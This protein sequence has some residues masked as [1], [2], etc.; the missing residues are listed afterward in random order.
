MAV[1]F[2]RRGVRRDAEASGQRPPARPPVAAPEPT[3]VEA[4][5]TQAT[6][7]I[8][9]VLAALVVGATALL[10]PHAATPTLVVTF[11]FVVFVLRRDVAAFAEV[12]PDGLRAFVLPRLLAA[13]IASGVLAAGL[14][15]SVAAQ[16]MT[17]AVFAIL[18]MMA[19]RAFAELGEMARAANAVRTAP[20]RS[21]WFVIGL[22]AGAAFF[23][24][25]DRAGW[26]PLSLSEALDL[27]P[28]KSI[29]AIEHS[30]VLPQMNS[31]FSH[32]KNGFATQAPAGPGAAGMPE[33]EW[34]RL[35]AWIS[36]SE[37][38]SWYLDLAVFA[39][40]AGFLVNTIM[41]RFLGFADTGDIK[42]D[43]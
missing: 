15:G 39:A 11:G 26:V 24:V 42:S 27:T 40:A 1:E 29:V 7:A 20:R 10:D 14:I 12:A 5:P 28:D 34:E 17:V 35:K 36:L 16:G 4:T 43:D 9:A 21:R 33:T 30:G 19:S 38:V 32:T 23:V 6:T 3:A 18:Y 13:A 31:T 37:G 22:L 25:N 41:V 8:A 2:G